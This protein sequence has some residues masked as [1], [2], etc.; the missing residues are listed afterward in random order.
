MQTI[1]ECTANKKSVL[2]NINWKQLIL[3]S[4]LAGMLIAMAGW[5]F[6]ACQS[7]NVGDWSKVIGAASF[8]VG[9]VAVI[10]LQANLYTGKIGYVNSKQL[11]FEA[12]VI[13]AV[14]LVVA[15]LIGLL[16]RT[17]VGT[18]LAMDSRL[19]KEWYRIFIDGFFCGALIYIAVEMHKKTKSFLPVI[20]CVTTFILGGFEHSIADMAYYGA[21]ELTWKGLGYVGLVILGNS[22]G[23]LAVR[24][25]QLG[26]FKEKQDEIN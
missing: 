2:K 3:K 13:L 14:N 16:Y 5:I 23:S 10:G 21:S 12:V 20:L 4:V 11:L 8:S 22:L 6:L 26:L 24:Y 17:C 7:L 19:S 1:K 18:S 9:L 15:F 25:L